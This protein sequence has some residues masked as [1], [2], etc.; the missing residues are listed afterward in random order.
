MDKKYELI[1]KML[2]I[3]ATHKDGAS[4]ERHEA[5]KEA[6]DLFDTYEKEVKST[7]APVSKKLC[8]PCKE[9]TMENGILI[10]IECDER[11]KSISA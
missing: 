9:F 5:I 8:N 3:G 11:Y 6:T 10:C 4:S 7:L 1:T 2:N